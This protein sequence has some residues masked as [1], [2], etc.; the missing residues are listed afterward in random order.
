MS[1]QVT[2]APTVI[3][4]T[5]PIVKILDFKLVEGNYK[6]SILRSSLKAVQLSVSNKSI[7]FKGCNIIGMNYNA[8]SDGNITF[9]FAQSTKIACSADYDSFYI[10]ALT[11][12]KKYNEMKG[13][14]TFFD[15]KGK[16][17]VS[18]VADYSIA[19][20]IGSP[21]TPV[22]PPV[23]LPPVIVNPLPLVN[24][25]AAPLIIP[26]PLNITNQTIVLPPPLVPIKVIP[27]K[28]PELN[29]SLKGLYQFQLPQI[30]F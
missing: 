22:I 28:I 4:N 17:V 18:F 26:A 3:D 14:Y 24:T 7:S 12:V 25:T 29:I 19:N 10:D 23:V 20:L 21:A 8:S 11:S 9:K 15:G 5:N 13:M 30:N 27:I 16:S 6:F 2:E 1:K